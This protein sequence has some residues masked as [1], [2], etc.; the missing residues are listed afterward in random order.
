[1]SRTPLFA[2]VK[3]ALDRS[4]H[5]DGLV[6]PR[7]SALTRRRLLRLSAA[8]AGAAALAP[9]LDWSA[10]AKQERPKGPIAIIGGG[11]AGLTAAYRLQA[12]GAT[13]VLFEASNR[14][15]GRMFTQYDFY[16]GMFCELGGEFV[17]TNHEI[18][19]NS[20]KRSA[21]RC[22]RSSPTNQYDDLYFFKG[23]FHTPKDM[24]DPEK[25]TGA[26]AP[27]AKRIAADAEKL[28]DKNEDWTPFARKLDNMSLKGYL[29]QFRGKT[30]DWAIDLLDVAYNVE[31]GLETKD[32]SSLNM[33]DFHHHRFHHRYEQALL[34]V[35]RER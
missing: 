21:W 32:Q 15:G 10:Y 17:D 19:K 13:P 4:F 33:V 14:W 23:I 6:L 26:F 28:T 18:C 2:A 8:A 12:A 30:D 24:V 25:Q 31:Y 16:K 7:Y 34:D 22:R 5:D 9:V 27:I 11:V 20:P 3:K 35:R 1:M 29:E